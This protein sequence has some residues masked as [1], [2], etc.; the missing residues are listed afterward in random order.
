MHTHTSTA[1]TRLLRKGLPVVV[2]AVLW[3]TG[4]VAPTATPARP[5]VESRVHDLAD[6]AGRGGRSVA[7]ETGIPT[8]A[9]GFDWDG[10]VEG[11]VEIRVQEGDQ[12]GPWTRIDGRPTE[13]PDR[14]SREFHPRTSA[15]PIWVGRGVGEVEVR[16]VEGDLRRVRLHAIRSEQPPPAGGTSPAGSLVPQPGIVSRAAWGADESY[17]NLNPG[18]SQPEYADSVRFSV[19]HHTADRN[20]YTA[21]EAPSM[22]RAIYY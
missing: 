9:V 1:R 7:V 16:V 18:C 8:H 12:W 2:A 3:T 17:R 11:A 4:L 19:V 15:G 22:V 10:S 6:S 14:T 21:A 13:G 5:I 20:T